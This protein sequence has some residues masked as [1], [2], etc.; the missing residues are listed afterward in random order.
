M[1]TE[2]FR[3]N[4]AMGKWT[5]IEAK[6]IIILFLFSISIACNSRFG[7]F[8]ANSENSIYKRTL[9]RNR[10]IETA[11]ME[12]Q[13][14]L[15]SNNKGMK[16]YNVKNREWHII[17]FL[18]HKQFNNFGI[19][20]ILLSFL[21]LLLLRRFGERPSGLTDDNF[22][23]RQQFNDEGNTWERNLSWHLT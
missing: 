15:T 10:I 20:W 21:P 1:K 7:T 6:S 22:Y 18:R 9:K 5:S 13:S 14:I 4:R 23:M 17:H 3:L 19:M 8:H 2:S 12:S 16:E 11:K